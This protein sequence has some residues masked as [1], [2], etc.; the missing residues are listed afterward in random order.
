[1]YKR[2]TIYISSTD[3]FNPSEREILV[4]RYVHRN[5]KHQFIRFSIVKHP[6]LPHHAWRYGQILAIRYGNAWSNGYIEMSV[7]IANNFSIETICISSSDFV[8]V[9]II[10]KA[11][12]IEMLKTVAINDEQLEYINK[13]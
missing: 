3:E 5:L 12:F 1:M 10:P 4:H 8:K 7:F 11:W 9:E 2:Q 6:S 13:L